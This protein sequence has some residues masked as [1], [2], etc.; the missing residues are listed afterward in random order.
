MMVHEQR[1]ASTAE[2]LAHFLSQAIEARGLS[3]DTLAERTKVP[4]ATIRTLC[5]SSEPAILPQRVY[6]RG[7]LGVIVRELG[8][9]AERAFDLFDREHPVE[10]P[11]ATEDLPKT[12]ARAVALVAGLGS[13]GILAVILAI[14][15]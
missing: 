13:L 5:G 12:N 3:V 7:Q 2:P 9:A 4:R 6:L 15:S 1:Y 10:A 11:I 14:V 8:V